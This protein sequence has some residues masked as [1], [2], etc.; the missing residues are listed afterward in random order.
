MSGSPGPGRRTWRGWR[1]LAAPPATRAD[2]R[3]TPPRTP[4]V[5]PLHQLGRC[6]RKLIRSAGDGVSLCFRKPCWE[7][8][9]GNDFP[10]TNFGRGCGA[11]EQV[12]GDAAVDY[13]ADRPDR[14]GGPVFVADEGGQDY[15]GFLDPQ[16]QVC[17][18]QRRLLG[19]D[20]DLRCAGHDPP[21]QDMRGR[22]PRPGAQTQ[23]DPPAE[24]NEPPHRSR[25]A[26]EDL[27]HPC[28]RRATGGGGDREAV[29]VG[30]VGQRV[31]GGYLLIPPA[32]AWRV[33]SSSSSRPPCGV[34]RTP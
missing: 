15:L 30:R 34:T 29:R 3:P 7:F 16:E 19:E 14:S 21:A 26:F 25:S 32:R 8:S 1:R 22:G 27:S 5:T 18:H 17:A 11:G 2:S 13:R 33:L 9:S 31:E 12:R 4:A 20:D 28:F 10:G 24:E 23:T 6:F